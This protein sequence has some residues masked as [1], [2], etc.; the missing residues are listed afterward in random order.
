MFLVEV[1]QGKGHA[2]VQIPHPNMV[3]GSVREMTSTLTSATMNPVPF[4][5]TG[6]H[7]TA[8]AVVA[9]PAMVVK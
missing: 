1:V 7:G 6:A 9:E 5:E 8:G 4:M 2:S 3:D